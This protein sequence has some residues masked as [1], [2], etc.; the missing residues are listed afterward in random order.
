MKL[1]LLVCAFLVCFQ[2]YGKKMWEA[3]RKDDEDAAQIRLPQDIPNPLQNPVSLIFLF[4]FLR[5]I[6]HIRMKL[7]TLW[8]T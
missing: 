7:G 6:S 5:L 1:L 4:L 3:R 8:P 2:A